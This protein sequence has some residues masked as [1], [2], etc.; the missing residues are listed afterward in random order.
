MHMFRKNTTRRA[1]EAMVPGVTIWVREG[2]EWRIGLSE[3]QVSV[4][5]VPKVAYSSNRTHTS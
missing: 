2:S 3:G 4:F 1:S 5:R